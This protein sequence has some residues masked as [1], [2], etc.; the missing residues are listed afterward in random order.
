MI[1]KEEEIII[2]EELE[3]GMRLD[4]MLALRY[5]EAFSRSYFQSLIEE[6][7]VLV[8]GSAVKKRVFLKP[9]DEIEIQ[10]AYPKEISLTP[11]NIPLDVLYEDEDIIVIN[12]PKGL[13]VHPA[14]G[15]WSH[16]FVNA[17][18]FHCQTAKWEQNNLATLRPGIV[19]RLDKDTTGVLIAAKNLYAQQ[20]LTESFTAREVYKEYLAIC[21]GNPHKVTIDQPI[22]RHP[23][24][25]QKMAVVSTGKSAVSFVETLKFDKTLSFV[26]VVIA[27]GRTHQIRV[28]LNFLNTP[29]LGDALYGNASANLKFKCERPYLHASCLKIIHPT[30]KIEMHFSAPLP[31]DIL[32]IVN[33]F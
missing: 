8:N 9:G 12:K 28:H 18:L 22:G 11:E 14:P 20:K 4:K 26:K 27:T 21:L 6:H 5:V 24:K 33:R 13:V 25:R 3:A 19:H 7:L 1:P 10:F 32:G 31:E 30:K 15:N 29:I 17:L 23:V 16:T 2:V